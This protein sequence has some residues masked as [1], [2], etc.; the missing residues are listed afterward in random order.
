MTDKQ[1]NKIEK[2]VKIVT[3]VFLT[4]TLSCVIYTV[5]TNPSIISLNF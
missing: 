1:I 2:V 4:I 3:I 5:I